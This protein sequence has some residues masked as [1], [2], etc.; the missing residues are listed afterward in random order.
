[1]ANDGS[2]ASVDRGERQIPRLRGIVPA[3]RMTGTGAF[4]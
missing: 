3:N 2:F 4:L 1:M